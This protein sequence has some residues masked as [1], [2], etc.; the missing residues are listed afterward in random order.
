MDMKQDDKVIHFQSQ[1]LL[2]IIDL[3][4]WRRKGERRSQ[5]VKPRVQRTALRIVISRN[6]EN[7]EKCPVGL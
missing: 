7:G 2:I 1:F 6:Q 4:L 3:F 5:M